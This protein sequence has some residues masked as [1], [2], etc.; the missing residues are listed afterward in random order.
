MQVSNFTC[1][2]VEDQQEEA[3]I[4]EAIY[5]LRYQVYVN[6]W[7]F[8]NPKDHPEGLEKDAYDQH[9]L[10]FYAYTDTLD[11]IIGTARLILDSDSTLPIEQHFDIHELPEGVPR[12]KIAEISRLAISKD[13]RRRAIDRVIFSRGDSTVDELEQH[14][15]AMKQVERERRKCEHELIRGIYLLIYRESLKRGLTHW[16]A[17]MAR[18]LHVILG[19]WGIQFKQVGP[20][21]EY[22]G[23]R[24]PY[25]LCIRDLEKYLAKRN[26]E[27][28]ELARREAPGS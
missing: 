21:R 14:Q 16:Y 27:L 26:P 28:L 15:A 9:S 17:V 25:L 23:L 7:G 4:L 8:E 24:A 12:N 5:R 20:A 19:R 22:H 6:E 1:Q 3:H 2:I 13:F 11:N 10:H 18:G